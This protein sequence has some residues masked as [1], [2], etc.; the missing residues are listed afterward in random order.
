MICFN[1]NKFKTLDDKLFFGNQRIVKA[2]YG[3]TLIYPE[4]TPSPTP[5]PITCY[6]ENDAEDG[7][8][9][10]N[11]NG[12]WV[13]TMDFIPESALTNLTIYFI[14]IIDESQHSVEELYKVELISGSL[15]KNVD[16]QWVSYSGAEISLSKQYITNTTVYTIDIP[17]SDI[18]VR[19]VYGSH[20]FNPNNTETYTF[21]NSNFYQP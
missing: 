2:Y 19:V 11:N 10:I 6:L 9:Q 7:K 20:T 8:H 3:N 18:N 14:N 1:G 5:T 15:Y 17:N 13:V 4:S 16:G 12:V 21:T